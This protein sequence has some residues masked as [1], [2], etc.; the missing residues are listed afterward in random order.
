MKL[1]LIFLILVFLGCTDYKAEI[2]SDTSWSG[3]FGNR[4]VDGSGD[5]TIDI[6]DDNI[7]CC[8]AQKSTTGGFLKI[9]I[10]DDGAILFGTKTDWVKTTAE[11]GVVSV[12]NDD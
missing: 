1:Y 4:T 5:K 11:Y 10:V 8:V 3:S 2:E 6:P 12:C 7:V 9:R